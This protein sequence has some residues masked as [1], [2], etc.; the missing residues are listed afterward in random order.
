MELF[1]VKFRYQR[2][3]RENKSSQMQSDLNDEGGYRNFLTSCFQ[4]CYENPLYEEDVK[5]YQNSSSTSSNNHVAGQDFKATTQD[6]RTPPRPDRRVPALDHHKA[7]RGLKDYMHCRPPHPHEQIT[8]KPPKSPRTRRFWIIVF[9]LLAVTIVAII[10]GVLA[11]VVGEQD[12][13][14]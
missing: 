8:F 9:G 13:I 3:K 14:S 1:S 6:H 10:I 11:T 5:E 12:S 7:S 4:A 2:C